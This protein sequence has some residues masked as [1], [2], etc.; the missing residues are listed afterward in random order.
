MIEIRSVGQDGKL[1]ARYLN[2]RPIHVAKAQATQQGEQTSVYV[3]LDDIGYPGSHYNLTYDAASDQLSGIY[4]QKTMNQR[5]RV[6]F[7]RL[8]EDP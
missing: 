2:P 4:T 3:E 8:P 1:D 7:I 6:A 5:H